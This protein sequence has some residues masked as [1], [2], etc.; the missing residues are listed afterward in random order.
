M[1]RAL[2]DLGWTEE[3]WNRIY[4]AVRE[5][6]Q[7]ARV[8]AQTLPVVG[9]VDPDEVAIPRFDLSTSALPAQDSYGPATGRLAIDSN[10]SLN[11]TTV[12]VNVFL[13]GHEV[14]DP[15]L[16][17][18]LTMFRRAANYVARLEDALIFNG[19]AGAPNPLLNAG[20][21]GIP[22]VFTISADGPA[23]EG[24]FLP[25][26]P[27]PAPRRI[28]LPVS[29]NTLVSAIANGIGALE[30]RGQLGPFACILSPGLFAVATNPTASLVLPRDRILPFLQGPLLR[31]STALADWGA[32]VALSANPVEIVLG[33]DIGVQFIQKTPETR[34][35]F[36]VGERVALRIKEWDAVERLFVTGRGLGF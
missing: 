11:L 32:I 20:F 35:V 8:A 28:P 30:G 21:A 24:L 14:A 23:V 1:D 36:R 27:A 12:S 7:K 19:R 22:P 26:R 29:G 34:C 15:A 17:A 5:E 18:A 3:Q 13:R 2:E 31:A 9:P 16:T 33:S 6:A 4:T 25:G 10:P